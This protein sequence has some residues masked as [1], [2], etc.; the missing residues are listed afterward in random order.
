VKV[1]HQ[2]AGSGTPRKISAKA[3]QG[4]HATVVVTAVH[5]TVWISIAPP[6]MGEAIMEPRKV[7]EVVRALELAQD[8]AK[9]MA[10][11]AHGQRAAALG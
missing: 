2:V 4:E 5:G 6:F 9:N 8:E 1:T 10:E 11:T 7:D 3:R